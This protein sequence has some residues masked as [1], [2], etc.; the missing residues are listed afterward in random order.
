MHVR[1]FF[2]SPLYIHHYWSGT[3]NVGLA[4]DLLVSSANV[5][6]LLVRPRLGVS[7]LNIDVD[8]DSN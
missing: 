1:S 2:T 7:M 3:R 5:A 8:D 4:N 6:T